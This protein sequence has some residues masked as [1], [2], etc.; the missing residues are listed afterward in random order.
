MCIWKKY[1]ST[2][3]G[4]WCSLV[5]NN[6]KNGNGYYVPVVVGLNTNWTDFCCRCEMKCQCVVSVF[7]FV[8]RAWI[9]LELVLEQ[10]FD[11]PRRYIV[12]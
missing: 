4:N 9:L 1:N 12:F 3:D 7:Y 11:K 6:L 10:C 5:L 2:A 8:M